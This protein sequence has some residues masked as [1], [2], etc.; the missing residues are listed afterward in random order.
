MCEGLSELDGPVVYV[1][2]LFWPR[3]KLVIVVVEMGWTSEMEGKWIPKGWSHWFPHRCPASSGEPLH[4][5][6]S[7][8]N[9]KIAVFLIFVNFVNF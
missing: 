4:S 7:P 3:P 2:V 8:E 1:A 5:A 6:K 9:L